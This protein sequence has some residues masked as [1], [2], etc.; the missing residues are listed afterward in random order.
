[1]KSTSYITVASC[2][3][4]NQLENYKIYFG[5]VKQHSLNKNPWVGFLSKIKSGTE[6]AK[7]NANGEY[8]YKNILTD[9]WRILWDD[10]PGRTLMGQVWDFNSYDDAMEMINYIAERKN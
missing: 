1:M 9:K 3:T 6:C 4:D 8:V 2:A 10:V 7:R 5:D